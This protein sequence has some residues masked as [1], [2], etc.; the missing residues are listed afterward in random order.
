M[1][2]LIG[3][4]KYEYYR[5]LDMMSEDFMMFINHWESKVP[6]T[7]DDPD[8]FVRRM[9]YWII[10]RWVFIFIIRFERWDALYM[11][12]YQILDDNGDG[13]LYPEEVKHQFEVFAVPVIHIKELYYYLD[14]NGDSVIEREEWHDWSETI[15][16][17]L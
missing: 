3:I 13:K 10:N 4:L 9:G 16:K 11:W 1:G 6:H 15:R 7:L 8:M 2:S 17:L 5:A 14:E 12:I